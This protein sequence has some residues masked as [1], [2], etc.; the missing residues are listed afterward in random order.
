MNSPMG[1]GDEIMIPGDLDVSCDMV[2]FVLLKGN[3]NILVTFEVE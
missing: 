2:S 3:I 1:P